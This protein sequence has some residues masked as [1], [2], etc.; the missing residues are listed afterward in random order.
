MATAVFLAGAIIAGVAPAAAQN[1]WQYPD[2]YFGILE[3]E[4]SIRRPAAAGTVPPAGP[5]MR[6]APAGKTPRRHRLRARATPQPTRPAAP[7][8][9]H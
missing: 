5:Q 3:I 7:P 2:P 8:V 6:A 1:D 4:K 9:G